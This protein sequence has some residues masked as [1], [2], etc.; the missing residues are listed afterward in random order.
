MQHHDSSNKPQISV[1][2]FLGRR[3]FLSILIAIGGAV[4]TG[5]LS[6]P[7][8]RYI[9]YPVFAKTTEIGWSEVGPSSDFISLSKPVKKVIRVEQRDGW[10]K[11]ISEKAV[12]V[13][14]TSQ[15]EL[16]AL[17]P[18][19]PHLGCPIGWSDDLNQFKCPCH[20]GTFSPD[21]TWVSGPP[22]RG[23]DSLETKNVDGKLMV[24]YEYFRSLS[25]KKEVMT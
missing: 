9:F 16:R 14:R 2:D 13:A 15:G 4:V 8:V 25:A 22:P 17:S 18:I 7:I 1:Q 3:S 20:M 10:R 19:C 24:K 23:M 21:G 12:Y 5:L 11:I 6:V